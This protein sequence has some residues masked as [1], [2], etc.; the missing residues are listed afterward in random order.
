MSTPR[1]IR[2]NNPGNIEKGASWKGLAPVQ[3]DERFATFVS[4]EYGIRAIVVTL[5]TYHRSRKAADGSPIDTLRE[6]VQRWAP[7][8]ENNVDAYVGHLDELHPATADQVLDLT[9]YA[10]MAPLVL[11]IIQHENGRRAGPHGGRWYTQEQIDE[12]LRLAGI[13]KPAKVDAVEATAVTAAGGAGVATA[14]DLVA[15]GTD[16]VDIASIPGPVHQ[17]TPEVIEGVQQALAPMAHMS[18]YVALALVALTVGLLVLR[19]YR[20]RQRAKL[21]RRA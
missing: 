17:A 9:T 5:L 7:A 21:E 15:R 8:F 18:K 13:V 2:N 11:G 6:V 20:K 14:V 4:P 1:G 10:N 16:V 12:G 19:I 3:T